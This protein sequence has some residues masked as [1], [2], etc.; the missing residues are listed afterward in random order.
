MNKFYLELCELQKIKKLFISRD[1]PNIYKVSIN[2]QNTHLYYN[3]RG[4]YSHM[5]FYSGIL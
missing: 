2:L 3:N 4:L 5:E 1:I